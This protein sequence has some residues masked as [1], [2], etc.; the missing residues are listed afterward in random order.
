MQRRHGEESNGQGACTPTS[1]ACRR[2]DSYRGGERTMSYDDS[3][4]DQFSGDALGRDALHSALADLAGTM[5]DDP[6]RVSDVHTR[7]RR[8]KARRQVAHATGI[9]VAVAGAVGAAAFVAVRPG[10]SHV[11]IIPAASATSSDSA[12]SAAP[13]CSAVLDSLPPGSLT[14]P[15][16]NAGP[17]AGAKSQDTP[18]PGKPAAS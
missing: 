8:L 17:D 11:S 14:P 18:S 2:L 9:A 13:A 15:A 4:S 16:A 5:P 6:R 12:S 1:A 7:A 10:T 3:T